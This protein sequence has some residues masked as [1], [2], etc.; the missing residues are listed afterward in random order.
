[1]LSLVADSATA[2]IG[3]LSTALLGVLGFGFT[4]WQWRQSSFRPRFHARVD[5]P[6][7]AVEVRISN[8]GR[9]PGPIHQI[10]L[11][12]PFKDDFAP[13]EAKLRDHTSAAFGPWELAGRGSMRAILEIP[14]GDPQVHKEALVYVEW[15]ENKREYIVPQPTQEKVSFRGLSSLLPADPGTAAQP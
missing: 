1:V 13:I 10:S 15:G 4:V 2:W 12:R 8:H 11:S 7:R 9:A 3:A 6:R 5:W 14:E